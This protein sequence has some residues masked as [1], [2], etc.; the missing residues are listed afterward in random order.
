MAALL[1]P[2]PP[3]PNPNRESRIKVSTDRVIRSSS[4]GLCWCL[5]ILVLRPP[6]H[7]TSTV[8]GKEE[9]RA[10]EEGKRNTLIKGMN[11]PAV[12]HHGIESNIPAEQL[13]IDNGY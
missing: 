2:L 4:T 13:I 12:N 8:V 11:G 3:E 9:D 1:L 7:C 6:Y 10:A 5:Y